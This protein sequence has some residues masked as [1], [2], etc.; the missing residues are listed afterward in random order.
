M[1]RLNRPGWLLLAIG[2]AVAVG[3]LRAAGNRP[4]TARGIWRPLEPGIEH[5]SI[6]IQPNGGES[7]GHLH[8]VR[9]DLHRASLR[10]LT[11]GALGQTAMTAKEFAESTRAVGVVNGGFFTPDQKPVGLVICDGRRYSR[12][13]RADWGVF[14]ISDDK[15]R[16]V[17]SR[18]YR[19]RGDQYA[20]ECGPRLV[21]DGRPTSLKPQASYRTGIGIT[22]E[23]SEVVLAV[24][25]DIPLSLREFAGV[26]LRPESKGG[27]GC[28]NALNLDGGPSSQLYLRSGKVQ[29]DLQGPWPVAVP[30]AVAICRKTR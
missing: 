26:F 3:L 8:A 24:C 4:R 29:L 11:A 16:I 27:L 28:R 14:A 30:D 23:G 20:L 21:V 17:Q 22:D 1:S 6:E 9:V 2:L 10:V 18:N 7:R 5:R 25:N 15:A 13:R 19:N 12:L